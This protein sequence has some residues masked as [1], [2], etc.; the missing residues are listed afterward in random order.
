MQSVA[1]FIAG[2]TD[3]LLWSA[4]IMCF[5]W[6]AAKGA[7]ARWITALGSLLGVSAVFMVA[8]FMVWIESTP[9]WMHLAIS[10]VCGYWSYLMIKHCDALYI[11]IAVTVMA[12][13]QLFFSVDSFI[14]GD[15]TTAL[16]SSYKAIAL[17]L[18]ILIMLAT[19]TNGIHLHTSIERCDSGRGAPL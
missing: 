2:H 13:L 18:H 10:V 1:Q 17:S 7:R 5:I 3:V 6:C 12:I 8:D 16:Y 15:Q 14:Y 11:A 19:L 4:Y 9:E